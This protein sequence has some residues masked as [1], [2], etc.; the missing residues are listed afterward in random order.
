MSCH[1]ACCS[2]QPPHSR[3]SFIHQPPF[4]TSNSLPSYPT[5]PKQ[6][7]VTPRDLQPF[8]HPLILPTLVELEIRSAYRFHLSRMSSESLTDLQCRSLF[9]LTRLR[10]HGV[11]F[12]IKD[13]MGSLDLRLDKYHDRR[14]GREHTQ[15]GI[16][17]AK[18]RMIRIQHSER[19]VFASVQ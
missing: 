5:A 11:K 17:H 6:L 15:G 9:P 13:I 14:L 18:E 16:T 7:Q 2:F 10:V 1:G 8:S 19:F 4:H 3:W 12:G